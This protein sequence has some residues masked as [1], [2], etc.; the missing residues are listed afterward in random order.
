MVQDQ[1]AA[2][3][4]VQSGQQGLHYRAVHISGVRQ[5][6]DPAKRTDYLREQFVSSLCNLANCSFRY[7]G[8][9]NYNF[10]IARNSLSIVQHGDKFELRINNQAFSHGYENSK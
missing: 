6:K 7:Q 1:E 8:A 4:E 10:H 5:E 2:L 9:F 3:V